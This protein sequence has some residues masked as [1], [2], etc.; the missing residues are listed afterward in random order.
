M[1]C[2]A[3]TKAADAKLSS[4]RVDQGFNMFRLNP[5]IVS[6]LPMPD[7]LFTMQIGL[8]DH[9][10]KWIF[11]FMKTEERLDKYNAISLYMPVYHILTPKTK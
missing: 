1:L 5:Y 4:R 6:D 9:P 11:H 10:Q 8:L 2:N 7:L 3:K